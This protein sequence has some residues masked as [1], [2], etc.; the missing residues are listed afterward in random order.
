VRR[1]GL[2]A[3]YLSPL[4][5]KKGNKCGQVQSER[6]LKTEME[7]KPKIE[8]LSPQG[9]GASD[10]VDIGVELNEETLPQATLLRFLCNI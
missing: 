8:I 6:I 10:K 3:L 4:L 1:L 2:L 7:T 5:S 9:G